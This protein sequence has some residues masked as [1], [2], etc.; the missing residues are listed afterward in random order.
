LFVDAG[1]A[2]GDGR[3]LLDRRDPANPVVSITVGATTAELPVNKNL[4]RIGEKAYAL[5]GVVVY[6]PKPDKAYIPLQ[7][8]HLVRGSRTALPKITN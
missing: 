3:V 4:L 5:E 7:A 6:A 2:F 8:V 1:Q